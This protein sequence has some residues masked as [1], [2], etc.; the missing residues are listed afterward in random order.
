MIVMT[1]VVFNFIIFFIMILS[2]RF[3]VVPLGEIYGNFGFAP[4]Y[5]VGKDS[6]WA[7][8]SPLMPF[9]IFTHM[10]IH[11]YGSFFHILSNMIFLLFL[12]V[13]FEEKVGPWV[14]L[15]IYIIAGIFGSIFTSMF[16]LMSAGAAGQ[17]PAGIGIGASGAIFGILGAF[18][19]TY[20]N[21]RIMFPL[22]I[23]RKWPVWVIAGIYFGIE[24][25]IAAANPE[26]GVGHY[27]H[28]GGFVGGLF[29]IP[30]INRVK[31]TTEKVAELETLDFDQL[32]K[33]AT[34]NKLKDIFERIKKEDER[35]IRQAWLEEFMKNIKCPECG[36][37]LIVK[38]GK[39]KCSNCGFKIKY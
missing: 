35:D 2:V 36:K 17:N 37:K 13:P 33:F 11:S 25:M 29:F 20:P 9:T 30:L 31:D 1:L 5:L 19:A 12:G 27:A 21:E 34:T 32:E 39:A 14:F 38:P 22:I 23:I 4:N 7:E 28:I 10:Y 3:E 24:T 6:G 16:A 8:Y 15:A 26:D 18:I